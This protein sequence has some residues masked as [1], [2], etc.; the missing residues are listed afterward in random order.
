MHLPPKTA[1]SKNAWY[2]KHLSLAIKAGR[3]AIWSWQVDSDKF[4]MDE[5]GFELW[6]VPWAKVVTFEELSAHIHPFDRNRVRAAF[7]A[8]RAIDGTYEIDFQICVGDEVRWIAARGQG[9]DDGI[10]GRT[11]SGI[12]LD[13]TG[14]KQAEESSELLAGEM[15]HR[16]KNLMAIATGLTKLT[17]RSARTVEEMAGDLTNR[18]MALG[19][20]HDLVRPL[21][22]NQGR[23]ALLGD[24]LSIL[25]A[26]YDETAAFSGRIRVAVTRMGI[27]E[28]TTIALAMVIHEL[29]TNSVK[30]GSLSSEMGFLDLSSKIDGDDILLSWTETGG[31]AVAKVPVLKGFGSDLIR[32][33]VSGQLGGQID[34]DWQPGGLV[35]TARLRQERLKN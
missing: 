32:R 16:V 11:M 23:A 17:A 2:R 21:P 6:G 13:V 34:Y 8:T 35:V 30:H 18:L 24:L 10:V 20:A 5:W 9:D 19:R 28:R 4:A 1:S 26:P 25:L 12:F 3:V 31:P 29:A 22:G 15:S 7:N 33:T 27:G 14:R